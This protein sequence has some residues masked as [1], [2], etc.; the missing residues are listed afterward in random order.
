MSK[1]PNLRVVSTDRAPEL[2]TATLPDD[3]RVDVG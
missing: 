1:A 2:L 3:D